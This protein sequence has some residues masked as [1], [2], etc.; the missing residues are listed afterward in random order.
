LAITHAPLAQVA[1]ALARLQALP[2]VP[3]F[4]T[5]VCKSTQRAPHTS[6]VLVPH[7][8]THVCA[9]PP[10]AQKGAEVAQT[11]VQPPQLSGRLMLVSQPSSGWLVQWA[12][13]SPQADGGTKQIPARH[14]TA[15]PAFTLGKAAQS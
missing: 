6:G 12:K 11:F 15:A 2:Q 13:P 3:Q 7:A 1:S 10:F 9:P 5:S 14:S 8:E 4:E